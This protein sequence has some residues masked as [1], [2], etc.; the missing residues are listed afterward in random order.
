MVI[1]RS[2]WTLIREQVFSLAA[3]K[4]ILGVDTK[5]SKAI[6]KN[7]LR[8]ILMKELYLFHYLRLKEGFNSDQHLQP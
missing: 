6:L 4:H 8:I 7:N 1:K 2:T 5:I 3:S